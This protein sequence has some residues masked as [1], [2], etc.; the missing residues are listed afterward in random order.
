LIT[1]ETVVIATLGT[2]FALH[3]LL[4]VLSRSRPDLHV[5]RAIATGYALRLAAIAGV[6]ATGIGQQLRGGD[7]LGYLAQAHQ[8]AASPWFS[9]AW[10]PLFSL[11]G[12][13]N[14]HVIV[15]AIQIKL[16]DFGADALRITQAGMA[17]AGAVLVVA[18]VYDL[19]GGRAA[20]L[21]AWLAAIEPTNVFFSGTLL[22]EPLL[23]FAIGLVV[24]GGVRVWRRLDLT[25]LVVVSA[26][27]AIAVFDR[28]YVGFFLVGGVVLLL[29]HASLRYARGR[30]R[31]IPIALAVIVG[32]VL[33]SPTVLQAVNKE[34]RVLVNSQNAN[35]LVTPSPSAVADVGKTNANNLAL[36][37]VDFSSRTA[38][39]EHLPQRVSDLLLKPYPW[40][41]ADW[42]QRLGAVGG[43]IVLALL[44]V[45]VRCAWRGRRTFGRSTAPLFYPLLV[46]TIA[47]SLSVG[48][49][50]TGFRYRAHLLI[51][52]MAMVA[53]LWATQ[54]SRAALPTGGQHARRRSGGVTGAPIPVLPWL[55]QPPAGAPA[56][57]PEA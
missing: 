41:L 29:L 2:W 48:N 43:L 42:S 44:V 3:G 28:G 53:I 35:T 18:A 21:I 30:L 7:E 9:A 4:R 47:F 52:A 37:P 6:S 17:L 12:T 32:L 55:A 13:N 46:M 20:K 8:I 45:L 14:L 57:W 54:R 56:G 49:A 39:V 23:D 24:F 38:I 26:G 36:E 34:Q 50:G 40:Q 22:K 10:K 15:F 51:P 5:T 11:A 25:G 16:F 31:A 1:V 27:C 19:A 33:I